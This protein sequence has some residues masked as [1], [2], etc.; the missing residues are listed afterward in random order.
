M[1]LRL[2]ARLALAAASLALSWQAAP[3]QAPQG[4]DKLSHILVLYLENRSF[5]N[6][7]GEFPGAYGI[8]NA[9]EAATQRDRDGKPYDKLPTAERPFDVGGNSPVVKEIPRLDGLDNKPFKIPG[10]RQWV[11]PNTLTK[12]PIHRFYTNRTQIN[13]GKND[14]FAAYSDVAGLVMG[15]YDASVMKDSNLWRLARR[16]TLLDNFFMGAFGGSFLNHQW[17]VCACAPVWT[18][19][20][21]KERSKV[22]PDGRVHV[23]GRVPVDRRVTTVAD[24]DYAVNTTQSVFL[25]DGKQSQLLESQTAP[26]IGDKLSEKGVH[27]AWYSRGW[28]LANKSERNRQEEEQF[29]REK[30]QW[31]HQPLAYYER[32]SPLTPSGRTERDKH[33]LDASRLADDIRSGD[34]PPVAFYKPV[35]ILNQHPEYANL[36]AADEEVGIIAKLMEESPMRDS[37]AIVIT[38]DENGGFWDHVRPPGGDAAGARADRFGPGSRIPTIVVSPFARRGKVDHTEYETTSILKFIGE[39]HRLNPLPSP[40]Y[41]AVTSLARAFDFG[42]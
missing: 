13:G 12:D 2:S 11:G 24:G 40:R 5:N 21:E 25:N 42:P 15:Y 14:L 37:Y 38:Y 18:N 29:E 30:F 36:T 41:G 9:G 39:R 28:T 6:L 17:L 19:P 26:T 10:V 8:A 16:H 20:P 23:D 22:D 1:A 35:G 7:F 3:A 31:H 27:W 4:L 33:L 34:L 32:F